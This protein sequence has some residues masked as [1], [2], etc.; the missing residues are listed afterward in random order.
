MTPRGAPRGQVLVIV[1]L[2]ITVLLAVAG[3]AVDIGRQVAE[4]RHVQNA[5]DA[6]ALAACRELVQG[7]TDN[8]A[9]DMGRQVAL[10]NLAGSPANAV[11]SIAPL[12]APTYDDGH[13]GDPSHLRSGII[14]AGATVRVAVSS[15]VDT[16]LA[17]V[18]GVGSLETVGRARCSL[19][20]S[21][22]VPI[23]ARRYSSP[24]GP[25]G[26]FTDFLATAATSGSGSV[27][28]ANPLG[29]VGRVPASESEPGPAFELYGPGAKANN[30]SSFRGFIALDV[31]NFESTGSR[32]YYNG[33]T[34]G[35][36]VNTLKD[37]E[38]T[39]ILDGYPGPGFPPV[40]VPANGSSQ[41]GVLSGNDTSMVVGNFDDAYAAGDRIL[42][43]IYNGTVMEIPDFTITPPP[44]IALPSTT[45]SGTTGPSFSVSRN[46]AFNSTVTLH[47]HGDTHAAAAGFPAYDIVP[48][49]PITPPVTGKM[50]E[51]TFTPNV[52]IPATSGTSVATANLQTNTIPP[53]IYTVWLEGH[54]GNPYFQT[55][56]T[57]LAVRIGGAVRDFSLGNSST[58]GSTPTYGGT[59]TLSAYVSTT[60]ATGTR[61][62]ASGTPVGLSWDPAS[63]STC[64]LTATS[65]PASQITFS[66]SSVT[67][68]S[69]GSGAL[70]TVSVNTG[71]LAAGCYR[72]NV[73]AT[74]TNGD[75]QPVTHI[76][77]MTFT[78]ATTD[79][80]G[81]Y[82]DII[83]FGVFQVTN[84]DANSIT[85]KAVTGVFGDPNDLALRRA[86]RP[87]LVPWS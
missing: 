19:Q 73:R 2:G 77:P 41:V 57:P 85:G 5:A 51:P 7:A 45:S 37:K 24:P 62:G 33:V 16:V 13:A 78:V 3:I 35:T 82:V 8:A 12:G 20:G 54:S 69:S 17:R 65:L 38:G 50:N 72:F 34:A 10:V 18:V 1:A 56:R 44:Y 59:V 40:S 25:G 87:R 46:A 63:F 31:R 84:V 66:A 48:D 83:G 80:G 76:Q 9:A 43:A 81:Q 28:N 58:S 67:P 47:L 4:R 68:T 15:T 61:W 52:F 71:G 53:G 79:A 70:S 27:D 49:P 22:A 23:V 11:S 6:G 21:P 14:V 75:G 74:G 55:R 39:Y 29:Y 26:G 36:N 32:A 64:N 60:N 42:L 30:D 86:Q